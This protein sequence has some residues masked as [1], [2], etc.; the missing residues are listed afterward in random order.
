MIRINDIIE[1]CKGIVMNCNTNVL[2]VQLFGEIKVFISN[3]VTLKSRECPYNEVR[4]AQEITQLIENIGFN[5]AQGWNER[6]LSEKVQSV[7][8]QGFKFGTDEYLWI[9]R[10]DL[11]RG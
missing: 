7:H 3:S 4:D 5:A 8:K 6:I 10:V 11:N 2:I 9:T 1:T